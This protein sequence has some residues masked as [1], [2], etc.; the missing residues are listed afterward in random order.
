MSEAL[1]LNRGPPLLFQSVQHSSHQIP[2]RCTGN[3]TTHG[4]GYQL[5]R[6]QETGSGYR[7]YKELPDIKVIDANSVRQ[8]EGG[9]RGSRSA[10]F[11]EI[12]RLR[13]KGFGLHGIAKT[14][15]LGSD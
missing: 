14:Y 8:A 11:F 2:E 5:R 15:D 12:Q 1:A 4:G 9:W 3:G 7:L 10:H 13:T 6:P